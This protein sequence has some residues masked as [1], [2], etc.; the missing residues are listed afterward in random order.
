VPRPVPLTC[1][2]G[3]DG[4][5]RDGNRFGKRKRLHH[6][7]YLI[8]PAPIRHRAARPEGPD[9]L[10]RLLEHLVAQARNGPPPADDMFVQV[11]ACADPRVN[12]PSDSSYMV[13]AFW[14]T[15]AGDSDGSGR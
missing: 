9:D 4:A 10:H 14:A 3:A 6:Y 12:R 7:L 1:G 11:L 5:A 8:D 2:P 13:A 15:T